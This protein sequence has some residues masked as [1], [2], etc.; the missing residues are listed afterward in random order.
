MT[1][2]VFNLSGHDLAQ[3]ISQG[4]PL[5]RHPKPSRPGKVREWTQQLCDLHLKTLLLVGRFEAG[6]PISL[7]LRK[8]A[9][10]R[11]DKISQMIP[12][13]WF[14]DSEERR[15]IKETAKAI[16]PLLLPPKLDDI[17]IGP[18]AEE[19]RIPVIRSFK[20]S[21]MGAFL[22]SL[23]LFGG[24]VTPT[25][26][27]PTTVPPAPRKVQDLCQQP[28]MQ[29]ICSG[30][31]GIPRAQM[32]Q[33]EGLVLSH[34]LK[35]KSDQG[36]W[37]EMESIP[38]DKL[39]P[40]QRELN[41]E[42]V[43][44]FL[45]QQGS[46]DSSRSP[47]LVMKNSTGHYAIVDGHHR[48]IASR[49]R[50]KN[51][52]AIIVHD[53]N[54]LRELR[55]FPGVKSLSMNEDLSR[56]DKVQQPTKKYLVLDYPGSKSGMFAT[57]ISTMGVFA[58]FQSQPQEFSGLEIDY[59]NLGVY[60]D[61][62]KGNNWWSYYF[63]PIQ[64]GKREGEVT[65][66]TK[67]DRRSSAQFV[68]FNYGDTG[69]R[70]PRKLGNEIVAKHFKVRPEIR[71]KVDDFVRDN[72][73]GKFVISIHYRGTDKTSE[74]PKVSY[75]EMA[76]HIR[77][78]IEGRNLTDYKLFVAT[79]EEAFTNFLEK[80]FPGLVIKTDMVR[81]KDGKPLHL[82]AKDPFSSGE[83]ALID[84]MLLSKGNVLIRTSS[85]LSL[86]STYLNSTLPV[87][88]VSQRHQETYLGAN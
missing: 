87:V 4:T 16:A 46:F 27:T 17:C 10:S 59:G 86:F 21:K 73:R 77:E 33:L 66:L 30:N 88:E 36:T 5:L 42:L 13:G 14:V 26:A 85:N 83:S 15:L 35:H 79:D 61:P 54:V 23:Y 1:T 70:M 51:Q 25:A 67:S 7:D 64:I 3:S 39:I 82:G 12:G 9:A 76:E 37:I 43:Y 6:E 40:T 34:Y 32:P 22:A 28:N 41:R 69:Q 57:L 75:Q 19:A 24:L 2:S 29:V 31:L 11:I 45:K 44:R 52:A 60:Y 55:H 38:A 78:Q 62:N 18:K 72:F 80:K 65:F 56:F 68:E 74:A 53:D 81:S 48:A 8:R 58:K 63:D 71:K 84:C 49:L 50:G 20:R 47:V